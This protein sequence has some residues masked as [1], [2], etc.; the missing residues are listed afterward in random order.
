MLKN[1]EFD[2]AD[3]YAD[4]DAIKTAFRR[5]INIVP[6]SGLIVAGVD[7]P[8]VRELIPAAFSRVATAGI[9]QGEW[10]AAQI[11]TAADGMAFDVL[12]AGSPYRTFL[13]SNP[14]VFNVQNAL[15]SIVVAKELG[16]PNDAHP[17]SAV[18]VQER[19]AAAGSSRRSKW[20]SGLR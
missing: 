19:E 5:L 20:R 6:R 4:L 1:V 12:R 8:V 16:I 2:H 18:D 9:G 7:S 14:R 3:I 11:K 10:Q 13:D 17:A 15:D